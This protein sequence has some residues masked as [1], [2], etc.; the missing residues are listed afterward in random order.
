ALLLPTQARADG[1]TNEDYAS[2][3]TKSDG[4]IEYN[5]DPKNNGIKPEELNAKNINIGAIELLQMQ[6]NLLEQISGVTNAIQGQK[7]GSGTPL[8]IY[9]LQ[10]SNAQINNRIYFEFFFQRRS[11]RDLKAVKVIQQY[12]TEDRNIQITG[13]DFD[14]EIKYYEAAKGRDLDIMISMGRATNT[15]VMRQVQDDI[16][17]R[18]LD[19]QL[20]D[21]DIFTEL[22]SLPFADKLRETINRKQQELEQAQQQ[23]A[24][25]GL[26]T[27]ADPEAM[28]AL[29]SAIGMKN[30]K[31]PGLQVN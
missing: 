28:A 3:M 5:A 24:A 29:Q 16:L 26:P 23:A 10:T 22:T 11:E 2:E 9:Q 25:Q 15:P 30:G 19:Q 7:A 20:I 4:V 8:G 13:K 27:E 6:M 1:W 17:L 31:I 12:Y 21:L 14:D 18:F